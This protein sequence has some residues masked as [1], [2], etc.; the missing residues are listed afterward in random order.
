MN[1][2]RGQSL[3]S[4]Y[5]WVLDTIHREGSISFKDLNKKWVDDD[6]SGGAE[7]AKRTFDNWKYDIADMFGIDI[8]NENCGKYRYYI[9]NESDLEGDNLRQ[10]IYK[11]F[12]IGNTLSNCQSI[13]DRIMLEPIP[14]GREFLHPIV[15]AMKENR[16]LNMTYKSYWRD[17][18]KNF[19]VKP[20]FIK[21][22]RQRWYLV[23]Q[24]TEPA[25]AS[26]P[27][28]I[29]S[30]DRIRKLHKIGQTFEMPE[31]AN[32]KQYFKGCFGIIAGDGSKPKNIKLKVSASQSNYLRDLPLH[33]SQKEVKRTDDYSIFTLFLRPTYDF[34][35]ELFHNVDNV[36]VLEPAELRA[37]V[38]EMII[39]M[40]EMYNKQE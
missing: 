18:E 2:S 23:A 10:W 30:L 37:E 33:H 5:A 17:E 36:E 1:N 32:A 20:F 39:R 24:G 27:P 6:I 35:Q 21:L 9:E 13:K 3:L 7:L 40:H 26:K 8:A 11:T 29:Y 12:S 4:K 38:A 31:D 14:S 15:E 19:N 25:Y 22:F 28:M 16:V 34:V